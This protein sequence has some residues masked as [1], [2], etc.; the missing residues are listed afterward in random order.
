VGCAEAR[1]EDGHVHRIL[2]T[3][4]THELLRHCVLLPAHLRHELLMTKKVVI[5]LNLNLTC[6]IRLQN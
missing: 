4:G 3:W 5:R 2:E 1:K 6:L